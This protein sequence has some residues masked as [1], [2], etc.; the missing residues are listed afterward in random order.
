MTIEEAITATL[1][2]E[3]LCGEVFDME[4]VRDGLMAIMSKPCVIL[5]RVMNDV[6]YNLNTVDGTLGNLVWYSDEPQLLRLFRITC[7][8]AELDYE[9]RLEISDRYPCQQLTLKWWAK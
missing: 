3:S 6:W 4:A 1:I 7:L 8:V 2:Q 5:V 9:T